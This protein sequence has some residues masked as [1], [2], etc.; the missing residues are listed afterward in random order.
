MKTPCMMF[1]R[2]R[3]ICYLL[4]FLFALP[5]CPFPRD[6]ERT[7]EELRER[8]L[9]VGLTEHP[10]WVVREDDGTPAGV[11]VELITQ[12]AQSIGA[13][14]EWHW[15]S[16]QHHIDALAEYVLDVVAGGYV[17]PNPWK[18]TVALTTPFYTHRNRIGV[19]P[20]QPPPDD[21]E[22]M[23]VA[24]AERSALVH[25]LRKHDA[26]PVQAE[27]P[28]ETGLP[29][30]AEEWE[31]KKHGYTRSDVQFGK[32]KHVMAAPPGENRLLTEFSRFLIARESAIEQ[33]LMDAP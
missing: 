28:F 32:V 27:D 23:E 30:A 24:V 13:E 10:P 9:R 16:S 12:F 17:E 20:G 25:K 3:A 5:A 6:P 8:P 2:K 7:F 29:V 22:G 1:V 11:E 18:K 26:L 4:L 19:P 21:F 15:G 31:L 33:R 14:V